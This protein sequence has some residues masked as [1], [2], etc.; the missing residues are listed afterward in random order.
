MKNDAWYLVELISSKITW[1]RWLWA[2][3]KARIKESLSIAGSVT[4]AQS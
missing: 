2:P 4:A 3:E 1:A